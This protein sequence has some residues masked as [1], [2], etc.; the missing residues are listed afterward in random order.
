M[1]HKYLFE[2]ERRQTVAVEF[3]EEDVDTSFIEDNDENDV[4][5]SD[6]LAELFNVVHTAA[7]TDESR[8]QTP[9]DDNQP[10]TE[11]TFQFMAD[12]Y[13]D[14]GMTVDELADRYH[15]VLMALK[16]PNI[17]AMNI[18]FKATMWED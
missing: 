12:V 14:L 5:R 8:Y 11:L 7:L 6:A 3:H 9:I 1:E 10:W 4:T 17:K 13:I 2:H 15:T 16:V 18:R